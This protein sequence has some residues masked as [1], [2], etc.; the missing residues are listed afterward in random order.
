MAR[1]ESLWENALEFIPERFA[2]ENLKYHPYANVVFS[3]G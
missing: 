3:A 1:D 2:A